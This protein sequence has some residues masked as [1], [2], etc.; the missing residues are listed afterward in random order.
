MAYYEYGGNNRGGF[1]SSI[2]PVT[3]N[4]LII[5][6]ILFIATLINEDFMVRT[7][8]LFYPSSYFFRPWQIVTHMFMHGGYAHIFFNMWSLWMFGSVLEQAI[9]S[10][11]FGVYYFI[12]GFGAVALHLFVQH[13][14]AQPLLEA[15]NLQAYYSLINTPTLGASGAVYGILIGYAMLYPDSILTLI[16][17]PISLKAKWFILI[18]AII[19][20]AT[21]VF[22]TMDGVAHFAHLGGMLVGFLLMLWWKRTRRLYDREL[23]F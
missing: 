6:V 7:F 16:F 2:P 21:G 23:W 4:L 17:P 20:L 12:S 8:A 13:L 3:R 15:N 19:E 10:R 11:K 18:F 1:L 9:G 22:G 5:N 14:Q